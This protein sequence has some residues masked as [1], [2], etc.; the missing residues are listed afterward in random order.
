MLSWPPH[1]ETVD[2]P[3]IGATSVEHLEYAVE[4]REISLFASNVECLQEPHE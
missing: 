4:A 1:Q 2:A 3:V